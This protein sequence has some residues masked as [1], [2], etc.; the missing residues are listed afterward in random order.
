MQERFARKNEVTDLRRAFELLD[1]K[2]DGHIDAEELGEY[3]QRLG[4]KLKKVGFV[5]ARAL[6]K[7]SQ[8]FLESLSPK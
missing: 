7:T 1:S 5:L 2:R 4:H 8:N 3:F 6:R